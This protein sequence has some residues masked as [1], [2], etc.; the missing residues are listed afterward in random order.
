[1]TVRRPL[2]LILAVVLAASQGFAAE[3]KPSKPKD[4]A[5]E[6]RSSSGSLL[7]P[8][9]DLIDIHTAGVL[10][11]GGFSSRTRFF[12][13]GGVMQWGN[14]GVFQRLNIGASLNVDKLLGTATPVQLTRPDLQMKLRFYDG[15]R[16]IPAFAMGF[17]GQGYLYNRKELRY[18]QR[19]RGLYFVGSQEVGLPGLQAHAGINISDFNSNAIFGSMA[20]SY[21]IRDKVLVMAEWDNINNYEDSRLNA[22]FRV[23]ITQSFNL[24]FAVRGI[25]QGGEFS[26]GVSRGAER[27]VQ[28]KYT[29]NF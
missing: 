14:F 16:M 12:S 17:D 1:M 29:G 19:Q 13:S 5:D 20:S 7:Q 3:G 23:Y 28:F 22:G 11:Y 2:A 15:D 24:D 8:D 26:N 27:I 18:N 6:G 10:D 25:G 21:N 4:D 9:T